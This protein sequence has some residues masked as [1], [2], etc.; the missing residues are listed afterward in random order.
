MTLAALPPLETLDTLDWQVAFDHTGQLAESPT[1][2]GGRKALVWVDIGAQQALIGHTKTGEVQIWDLPL[3]PGCIALSPVH[4]YV[5]A[6][7]DGIY[8]ASEWGGELTPCWVFEPRHA[9]L[10][11]NDGRFDTQG[12]FWVGS[13]SDKREAT[14]ELFCIDLSTGETLAHHAGFAAS[15]GLAFGPTHRT[16]AD[17][18]DHALHVYPTEPLSPAIPQHSLRFEKKPAGWQFLP[19]ASHLQTYTGRPDGCCVDGDGHFWVAMYEGARVLQFD[20]T[21]G[22]LRQLQAPVQRPT[23]PCWAEGVL[24]L[25][26][27]AGPAGS[28]EAAC[29]PL[30]GSVWSLV[31]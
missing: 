28:L 16:W 27:A 5:L 29:Q 26:S 7:R 24:Y 22:V 3:T 15:N 6:L 17:T 8:R 25:T 4:G 20:A 11:L 9:G 12:R 1:W 23:M 31:L 30:G 14:A 10:R 13:Y 21:G 2:C 19:D 18:A